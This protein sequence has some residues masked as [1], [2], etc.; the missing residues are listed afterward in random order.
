MT[1]L[2]SQIQELKDLD[3]DEKEIEKLE[4]DISELKLK[5]QELNEQNIHITSLI[6]SLNSKNSDNEK[7]KEKLNILKSVQHVFRKLT[8][9][10]I[11]CC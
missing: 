6:H 8:H 11:K 7:V 9:I 3:Y 4:K 1:Q 5:K 2:K 10:Q